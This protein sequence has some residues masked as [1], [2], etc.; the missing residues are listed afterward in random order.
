MSFQVE[1]TDGA[2]EDIARNA[3]WWAEHHS[4]EQA[5]RW[6]DAIYEQIT[7]L[8][9]TPDRH[10]LAAENPDFD[11]EIREKLVGM[12]PRR[13][14]RAVFTIQHGVVYVLT[15]QRGSQDSL[16]PEDIHFEP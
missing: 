15:V 11:F 14:Y 5:V 3:L 7:A 16:R 1:I 8:S 13:G 9:L 10:S 2:H 4:Y 6:K 12:G